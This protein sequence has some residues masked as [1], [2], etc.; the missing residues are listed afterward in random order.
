MRGKLSPG[1]GDGDNSDSAK[2]TLVAMEKSIL[3]MHFR[4]KGDPP[5]NVGDSRDLGSIPGL[6]RSPGGGHGNPL[7]DCSLK[8]PHGQRSLAGYS[9]WGHK[10][11]DITKETKDINRV[12]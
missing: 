12:C 2:P 9:P 8:N 11:L 7:Q 4:V 5:A 3:D 10:E 1:P 6:E